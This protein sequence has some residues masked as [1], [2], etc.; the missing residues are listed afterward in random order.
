LRFLTDV[1]QFN[2][3]GQIVGVDAA[4]VKALPVSNKEEYIKAIDA[5]VVAGDIQTLI[6]TVR[7]PI[8]NF[9]EELGELPNGREAARH[10]NQILGRNTIHYGKNGV[11][12]IAKC[13][14]RLISEYG[15]VID[16]ERFEVTIQLKRVDGK[17]VPDWFLDKFFRRLGA[18]E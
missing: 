2:E 12:A 17:Q 16:G 14:E 7:E 4:K 6:D 10:V 1:A 15:E 11:G 3:T 9:A 13:V 18:S 8:A 5:A